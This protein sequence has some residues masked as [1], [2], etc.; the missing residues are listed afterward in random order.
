MRSRASFLL[1]PLALALLVA[2]VSWRP[3]VAQAQAGA[4]G[5]DIEFDGAGPLVRADH[6]PTQVVVELTSS[7]PPGDY[8]IIVSTA[9]TDSRPRQELEQVNVIV[10]GHVHGPTPDIPGEVN[11]VTD[12]L[13]DYS[14]GIVTTTNSINEVIVEHANA[15]VEDIGPESLHITG[16]ELRCVAPEPGPATTLPGL[17]TIPETVPDPTVK[18]TVVVDTTAPEPT[19]ATTAPEPV[20]P[21]VKGTLV[22]LPDEHLPVTGDDTGRQ[23]AGGAAQLIVAGLLFLAAAAI[24][25]QARRN[26]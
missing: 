2:L 5:A 7:V 23:L 11:G 24:I 8:E 25:P 16:I 13:S 6:D 17:V 1:V 21:T 26:R 3:P 10:D 19:V 9:D 22:T 12:T 4:C 15:G 14:L 18:G 20:D